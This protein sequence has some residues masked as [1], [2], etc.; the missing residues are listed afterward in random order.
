MQWGLYSKVLKLHYHWDRVTK[1]QF[2]LLELACYMISSTWN[3]NMVFFIFVPFCWNLFTKCVCSQLVSSPCYNSQWFIF[4]T[5]TAVIKKI[6]W[7]NGHLFIQQQQQQQVGEGNNHRYHGWV[8]LG[9]FFD[10][11]NKL[12]LNTYNLSYKGI[13]MINAHATM[14]LDKLIVEWLFL[15][16]YRYI[17]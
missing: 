17:N 7:Y 4:C 10:W 3:E 8:S 12:L 6:S 15:V 9:T 1:K 13:R 16:S 14:N 11:M 5:K 2:L